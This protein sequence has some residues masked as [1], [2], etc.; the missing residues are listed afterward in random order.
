MHVYLT[1]DDYAAPH[2]YLKDLNSNINNEFQ[3]KSDKLLLP[4]G[5]VHSVTQLNRHIRRRYKS[6]HNL[7]T[8]K[9]S[10]SEETIEKIQQNISEETVSHWHPNMTFNVIYDQSPWIEGQVPVPLDKFIVFEP[11]TYR[12]YPIVYFND[13]WNLQRDYQPINQ[14]TM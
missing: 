11:G 12:Y 7:L 4:P 13:F 3:R 1:Q 2:E 5:T 9:T 6:T 8:G 10:A 14:T